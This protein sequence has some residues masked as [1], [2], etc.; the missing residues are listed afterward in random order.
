MPLLKD[1]F[2]KSQKCKIIQCTVF[3]LMTLT[4][5]LFIF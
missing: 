1:I 3:L 4:K 2:L 5:I